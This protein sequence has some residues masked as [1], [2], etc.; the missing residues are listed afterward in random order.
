MEP[1]LE[2][3]YKVG[4]KLLMPL[5]V[6]ETYAIIVD[7]AVKLVNGKFGSIV[8]REK[9]KFQM[10]YT[11]SPMAYK[12]QV[13]PKAFAYKAFTQK[14]AILVPTSRVI[15]AHPEFKDLAIKY[16]I[17]IPLSNRNKST[18]VLIINSKEEQE[19]GKQELAMLKLFGSL[20][21]L[22]IRK[23]QLY[24]ETKKAVEM[25]DHFIS[26]AA[27]ELRTPLTSVNGYAQLLHSK[28]SGGENSESRWV[29]HLYQESNRLTSL[30]NELLEIN[31]IKTGQ[32]KFSWSEVS[33]R[34]IIDTS[35]ANFK[36]SYPDREIKFEDHLGKKKDLIIGDADKILQVINNI[37]DNGLKFS[38]Y[39]SKVE[40]RLEFKKQNF[41]ITVKDHG[42]GID[43]KDLPKVFEGYFIGE[44]NVTTEGM[45]L[46]LFLVND[47]LLR[48]RG[49]V[50]VKSKV[51]KG[52][53]F[54]IK[55]PKARI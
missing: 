25:R 44:N 2:K 46:G 8:I 39:H 50:S 7:E 3:L 18:G 9:D 48:H 16:T 15:K 19:F 32:L 43:K 13:R 36:F 11:S 5:A 27:H 6:Q 35:L 53:T 52:T 1:A 40:V 21:S 26:M 31:I 34:T 28:L 45:G 33:L 30:V 22:A 37:I 49:S 20:A 4:L 17:Y 55:L 47:I 29:E 10:V 41:V 12:S 24:D 23:N 51:G 42:I 38:P 54:E 14:K